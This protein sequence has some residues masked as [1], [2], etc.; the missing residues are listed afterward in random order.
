MIQTILGVIVLITPFIL[1]VNFKDKLIGALSI[2]SG[3]VAM[4]L[5]VS[6]LTQSFHI[7]SY[8]M[9]LVINVVLSLSC[10][11]IFLFK[12]KFPAKIKFNWL[13]ILALLIICFELLSVHYFYSGIVAEAEGYNVV[14]Y[15]NYHYP[16]YSDEWVGV[17]FVD[18]SI[19]SKSL[20]LA[21][22]L[23]HNKPFVNPLVIF[24]SFISEIFLLLNLNPIIYWSL[25]S[26]VNGLIISLLIYLFLRTNNVST[27]SAVFAMLSIP[28]IVNGTNIPGIWFFTP[29]I[30][31]FT[32]L[33]ISLIFLSKKESLLG[34]ST[35]LISL[36]LYPP[37]IV[38]ILPI[39]IAYRLKFALYSLIPIGLIGGLLTIILSVNFGFTK[40]FHQVVAWLVREN[41]DGGGI[42]SMPIWIII[43]FL[44]LPLVLG[45]LALIYKNKN[46]IIIAPVFTGLIFWILYAFF[47]KTI[48]I[49][50]TRIV[51][52]TSI[53]L[54][55]PVGFAMDYLFNYLKD[56]KNLINN[57]RIVQFLKTVFILIFIALAV[58]YPGSNNWAKLRLS[59]R[60]DE[61][62]IIHYNPTS[63]ITRYLYSEDLGI[64][65]NISGK[66]FITHPWKGLAIGVATHNFPLDSKA[67]TVS[68]RILKYSDFMVADCDKKQKYIKDYKIDYVYSH[69]I[70]CPFLK[71]LATSEEG[72]NLYTLTI[73]INNN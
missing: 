17:S 41:L 69:T 33:L 25:F 56:H 43:P 5:L 67:S 42:A 1:V 14:S 60:T 72:Y 11:V 2:F 59:I 38:F 9:I 27:F 29:F 40:M 64:F 68:N 8:E 19:K 44:L 62:K 34:I 61:N 49:D 48:I 32:I 45:G 3:I 30:F 23:W 24:Y 46:N 70:N 26:I 51:V 22:P 7:F 55:I 16:Y 52:I 58:F 12:S 10:L 15:D 71:K 28:L 53:L 35:S 31:S 21:N 18:Y 36:I 6:I 13:A 37:M 63:P 57:Q 73:P 50:Q 65:K 47:N 39:L 20:P 66:V 4:Q 54:M